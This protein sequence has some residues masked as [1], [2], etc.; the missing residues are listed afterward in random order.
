M[1]E[2]LGIQDS[3]CVLFGDMSGQPAVEPLVSKKRRTSFLKN[4]FILKFYIIFG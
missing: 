3:S 4:A 1:Q 2:D